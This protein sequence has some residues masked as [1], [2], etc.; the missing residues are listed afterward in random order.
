MMRTIFVLLIIAIG[1]INSLRGS[2]YAL[3]FYLWIAY[4]RPESWIWSD[5]LKTFSLSLIVGIYLL[6]SF[7]LRGER[8]KIN[9]QVVLMALM[10]LHA[11]GSTLLSDHSSLCW[12]YWVDLAKVIVVTYILAMLTNTPARLKWVVLTIALSLSFEGAK[13]GW[14][15]LLLHPGAINTN[16]ILFLGDNNCVAVGMVMLVPLLLVLEAP[17]K[18]IGAGYRFLA[19]G[20]AYRALAT[21]SRGGLISFVAMCALFW[22]RSRHRIRTL[23]VIGVLAAIILPLFPQKF[24]QRMS[25]ITTKQEQMDPS[26]AGRIY[27][28]SVGLKMALDH[29]FFGVGLNGYRLSYDKYDTN[30]SY[31]RERSVH[32]MWFGILSESGFTGL[33]LFL[34]IFIQSIRSCARAR[35]LCGDNEN[36]AFVKK[37]ATAIQTSLIAAAIGGAFLP[38][39]YVE[40]LWHFFGLSIAVEQ[41]ALAPATV[42]AEAAEPQPSFSEAIP[43][44]ATL[45]N[46]I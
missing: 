39:Q 40:M 21:Y 6:A 12:P 36:V 45:A 25:T 7:I 10:L 37:Y 19:I 31:G 15:G 44:S 30:K 34:A 5:F 24:W 17:R 23:L 13:Q 20:V 16:E 32:S 2:F 42:S 33:L 14:A 11:L 3:L 38:F 1:G 26:A 8:L 18:W 28:W 22:T 43:A 35:K 46:N 41:I 27:F 4:F 29:P 9:G